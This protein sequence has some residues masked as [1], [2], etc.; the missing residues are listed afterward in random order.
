MMGGKIG[1]HTRIIKIF[2][3]SK[4]LT[5]L[6]QTIRYSFVLASGIK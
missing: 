5:F 6:Q 4:K 3:I 2:S 1:R